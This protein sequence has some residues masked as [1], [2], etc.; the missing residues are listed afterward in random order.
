MLTLPLHNNY[1]QNNDAEGAAKLSHRLGLKHMER[2][3]LNF[4]S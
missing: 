4:H 2:I 3:D 1:D